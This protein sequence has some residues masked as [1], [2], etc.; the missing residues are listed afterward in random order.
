MTTWDLDVGRGWRV[1]LLFVVLLVLLA[2]G[3]VVLAVLNPVS[4][5]TFLLG[6]GAAGAL[7][8][9][10][11]V[12]YWIWGLVNASYFMDRNLIVVGWGGYKYEIPMAT[13]QEVIPG[14]ELDDVRLKNVMRWPGYFVGWGEAATLGSVQFLATRPPDRQVL[15]RTDTHVYALSPADPEAFLTALQERLTMGPTQDVEARVERPTFYKWAIWRDRVALGMLGSGLLLLILLAGV[16]TWRY[17]ALP[18]EI[19]LQVT[20]RGEPLLVADAAR[21][22][23]LA[24]VGAIFTLINGGL[25]LFLYYRRNRT[26]AYFLWIGLVTLQATLWIAVLS[27]FFN[28]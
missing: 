8:G 13:V 27:V 7:A 24:L 1:G 10:A 25:G 18:S 16:L 22:F 14:A 3:L 5:L 15:I 12:A 21:I 20:P 6:L 2:A 19:V 17:P 4:I 23:Y 9:A 28:N 11:L 26:A